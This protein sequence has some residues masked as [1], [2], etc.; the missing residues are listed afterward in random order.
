M[1]NNKF[2]SYRHLKKFLTCQPFFIWND[3]INLDNKLNIESFEENDEEYSEL[4]WQIDFDFEEETNKDK[5]YVEIIKNGYKLVFEKFYEQIK[6]QNPNT[7]IA[8]VLEKNNKIAFKKTI[9]F[10]N[11]PSI[12]L[13]IN[14]V[15]INEDQIAKPILLDKR[16]QKI[17]FLIHSS[18]TKLQCYIQA[19]FDF[20][21]ISNFLNIENISLFCY[22]KKYVYHQG[23]DL[24][25]EESDYCWTQINGPSKSTKKTVEESVK[26]PIIEK[27]R[28]GIILL[29]D[30]KEVNA[31][32]FDRKFSYYIDKIR[33]S[34]YEKHY[35]EINIKD[36]TVWGVNPNFIELFPFQK[37]NIP[38][39]S[40][41][42]LNKNNLLDIKNDVKSLHSFIKEKKS[43]NL[44]VKKQNIFDIEII[45]K[46]IDKIENRYC[47]WYDFEGFSMP[48]VLIPFSKPY[49]QLVFQVSVIKTFNNKLQP[50]NNIVIDPKTINYLDFYEIIDAIYDENADSYIVYNKGYENSRLDEMLDIINYSE[51][52]DINKISIYQKKILEIKEKTVDLNDLFN[53][54]SSNQKIPPIFLHE[55]MGFSSIKKIEKLITSSGIQLEQMIKP[56]NE[57]EVQNGLMAMNK[58]IQRYLNS[59]GDKEWD[60]VKENLKQYCENDVRAMIMVFY[61]IKYL[62]NNQEEIKDN[63]K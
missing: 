3:P 7:N 39:V 46:Y 26:E 16:E 2:I 43:L 24:K 48:Y 56:Y 10:L 1:L 8:I 41:H 19:Y 61:Y 44:V 53:I 18:K 29:N 51:T 13:I 55:L 25:F 33:E 54:T 40:G 42:L 21:V 49:Q 50:S 15:F 37:Y 52:Q 23:R 36:K 11:D 27:I 12:Q 31:V 59:I 22:D 6:I 17:S 34:Y 57:L 63:V 28:K 9:E 5:E 35:D 58:A 60:S 38:K 62:L 20:N 14:P 45:K 47:V 4:Y 30:K 32:A